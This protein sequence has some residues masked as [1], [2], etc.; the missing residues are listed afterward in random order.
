MRCLSKAEAAAILDPRGTSIRPPAPI[1]RLGARPPG[2]IALLPDFIRELSRWLSPDGE[3]LLWIDH[4][5]PGAYGF[6]H[7]ILA[8]IRAGLREPRALDE[9]PGYLFEAQ[10]WAAEDQAE[11]SIEMARNLG[12][13][14]G[15]ASLV[16]LT[17]SYGWLLSTESADRIEFW[18][19]NF[20]FYSREP[21]QI[22][23]AYTIVDQ[24][25][26]SRDLK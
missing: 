14:I 5:E 8:L 22:I 13:L 6:D 26:C 3:R 20:F 15:L 12:E 7:A 17:Q 1:D 19:G 21:D 4:W 10:N 2:D 18:E 25:D 9:A 16:M 23:R 11:V 24:F